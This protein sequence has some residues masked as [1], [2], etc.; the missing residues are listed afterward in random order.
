MTNSDLETRFGTVGAEWL[1][2]HYNIT[3]KVKQDLLAVTLLDLQVCW[4]HI[5]WAW[6][7]AP[8]HEQLVKRVNR[9]VIY[10]LQRQSP[11]TDLV[12][13][14]WTWEYTVPRAHLLRLFCGEG[15]SK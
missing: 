9:R 1:R 13:T 7:S 3:P 14:D 10:S 15:D 6:G 4:P 12:F 8:G 2:E 5:N 11:S